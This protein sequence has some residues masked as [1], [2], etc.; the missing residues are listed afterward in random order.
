MQAMLPRLAGQDRRPAK[1]V[2]DI[3]NAGERGGSIARRLLQVTR[4][5][6]AQMADHPKGEVAGQRKRPR[7][8]EHLFFPFVA[9]AKGGLWTSGVEEHI[10]ASEIARGVEPKREIVVLIE[11]DVQLEKTGIPHHRGGECASLLGELRCG[12]KHQRLIFR[13]VVS[14][15]FRAGAGLRSHDGGAVVEAHDRGHMKDVLVEAGEEKSAVAA[16]GAAESETELLLLVVR[17]EVH[18]G[19]LGGEHAVAHVIETCAV[20]LIAARFGDYVDHSPPARPIS[21]P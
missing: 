13:S 5:L 1:A 19:M 4:E 20:G 14:W 21:A 3:G 10:V 16:N 17:L 18:E 7:F 8:G 11:G 15:R 12:R 9:D 6:R 2:D